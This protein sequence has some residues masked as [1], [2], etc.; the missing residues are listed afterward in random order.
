MLSTNSQ[1]DCARFALQVA[2]PAGGAGAAP[3][4]TPIPTNGLSRVAAAAAVAR[5]ATP[6]ACSSGLPLLPPAAPTPPPTTATPPPTKSAFRFDSVTAQFKRQLADLM[7]TLHAMQPHYV[8][9]IK[10]SPSN[11]P[12]VFEPNYALQQLRCGGALGSVCFFCSFLL[13][14][15]WRVTNPPWPC[16]TPCL[17]FQA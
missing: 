2:A 9:C 13:F 5:G 6:A 1:W 4:G 14:W 11:R 12:G 15:L 16:M 17:S 7:A 10:P 8:R 3:A